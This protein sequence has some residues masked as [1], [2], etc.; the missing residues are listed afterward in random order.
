[1]SEL[2]RLVISDDTFPRYLERLGPY[3]VMVDESIKEARYP[4]GA[5]KDMTPFEQADTGFSTRSVPYKSAA[6]MGV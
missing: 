6:T 4:S 5:W 3:I 1:M 2:D